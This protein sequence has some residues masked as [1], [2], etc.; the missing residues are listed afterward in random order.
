[1]SAPRH[2]ARST[3]LLVLAVL[4]AACNVP[5]LT[6]LGEDSATTQTQVAGSAPDTASVLVPA[7]SLA[8]STGDGV[9]LEDRL[10]QLYRLA[11]PATV[12]IATPFGCGTGFVH[13]DAGHIV[14][15]HHVVEGASS[16]EVVF[17]GNERRAA[18]LSGVDADADLAV[19][20]V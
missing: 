17:A 3:L 18:R 10:I 5:A 16:F 1:G 12:Y 13:D 8:Q 4:L 19:L 6:F 20:Q 14:T 15:N 11:N 7:S 9:A 2:I